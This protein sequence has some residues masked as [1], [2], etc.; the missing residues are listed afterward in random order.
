MAGPGI[1]GFSTATAMLQA[2]RARQ[3]SA[4]ELLE[5]YQR[6]IERYNPQ[7]NAIVVP[8]LE[9]ARRAAEAADAVRARGDERPLLGLPIT[10]K[11][12]INVRG[13][14]TTVGIPDW[15]EARVEVDAPATQRTQ[16]AGAVLLGKTNVPPML[17]DWQ[18]DN[19]IYGRS[20]NPWDLTRT[21]GG[22]TGGGAAALAAGL[23][24]LEVGS[25]IGGSIRVPAA[26]CG[27]YGHRPSD[28]AL[29]KSGQFPFPPIPNPLII[30]AVQG[31]L[32]R[33]AADLELA[34]DVLAGPEGGEEAA[35]RLA[36]P[37]ARH[38]HLRDFRVAVLPPIDWV[39][40]DPEIL[41][42]QENILAC[43]RH[44]GTQMQVVQPES[45]GDLRAHHHLYRCL[46]AAITG[47]RNSEAERQRLVELQS[48][49]DDEFA[50]AQR[51][52]LL[53]SLGD[54]FMWYGQREQYR[55]AYRAFFREWDVL[56]API[57]LTPAFP[58]IRMAWP[59]DAAAIAQTLEVDGR[60]VPYELPLVYPGLAT[61]SG[62]PATAFPVGRTRAGLPI[63]LQ[64][65]GP[66]LEDRTPI[67]FAALL[68]QEIGGYQSPPGYA[69]V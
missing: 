56:L 1:D 10:L 41:A 17:A 19:V 34:L 37:P 4:C 29:P 13:L 49:Q 21:P 69:E 58:H 68:G 24:A 20:N 60:T 40:V 54:Y 47:A 45:F 39:P 66:Y 63:G 8:C 7:L 38:E 43:L 62:Q 22:S 52:G 31:P 2:L 28:S 48:T 16:A 46:L 67:R 42:A 44:T 3:V 55:A 61:L 9:R 64:V 32:A 59:R 57:T 5:L 25:D 15:R 6:R 23:T 53:A 12:S 18:A 33:S 14:P 11:E 27:V 35:W 51:R 50:E 65:I 36:I 26:F 30:M